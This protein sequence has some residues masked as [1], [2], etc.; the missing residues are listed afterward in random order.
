MTLAL[1]RGV[2]LFLVSGNLFA[3]NMVSRH[4][5]DFVFQQVERLGRITVC[6]TAGHPRLP[7]GELDIPSSVH[8]KSTGELLSLELS[9][10]ALSQ[11]SRIGDHGLR[12]NLFWRESIDYGNSDCR[13]K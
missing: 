8:G 9:R 4:L 5:V 3:S 10:S 13:Q 11:F 2:D 1:D 7:G 12:N 6:G